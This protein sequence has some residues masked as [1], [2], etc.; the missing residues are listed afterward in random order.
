M[1]RMEIMSQPEIHHDR[2]R[3]LTSDKANRKI[4]RQTDRNLRGVL[5]QGREAIES[6]LNELDKEWDIDRV[7]MLNFSTLVFIQLVLAVK[8]DKRW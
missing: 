4:D 1:E 3:N 8:K 5:A 6:R 2:I 7:L